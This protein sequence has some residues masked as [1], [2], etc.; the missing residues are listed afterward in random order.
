MAPEWK[1]PLE[2]L[3]Q[4][5]RVVFVRAEGDPLYKPAEGLTQCTA[6][7]LDGFRRVQFIVIPSGGHQLPDA[8][9]FE[10][11]VAAL[12]APLR[13]A[14]DTSPTTGSNP[15]PGQITQAQRILATAEMELQRK[16]P[17]AYAGAPA[18]ALK[19]RWLE[20]AR[21]HLKQV[22]KDYPSTPA[23]ARAQQLLLGMQKKDQPRRL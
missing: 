13:V 9:W 2:N 15:G 11:A 7:L 22:T 23:A 17:K 6:L 4:G 10:K 16:V 18:A 1:G 8:I 12:E 3:K 19:E 20:S 5:M 14:I 21:D